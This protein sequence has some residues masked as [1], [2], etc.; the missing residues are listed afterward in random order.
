MDLMEFGYKNAKGIKKNPPRIQSCEYYRIPWV[1]VSIC[2]WQS[3]FWV[4]CFFLQANNLPLSSKDL[5][6]I[7]IE[8][9]VLNWKAF[10]RFAGRSVFNIPPKYHGVLLI[11]CWSF[12]SYQAKNLTA[13]FDSQFGKYSTNNTPP[14]SLLISFWEAFESFFPEMTHITKF[15]ICY[16]LTLVLVWSLQ[17]GVQIVCLLLLIPAPLFYFPEL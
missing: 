5:Q 10:L 7:P 16:F 12:L 3:S 1:C 14:Q 6:N 13:P 17:P 2:F 15:I 8:E 11:L 4:S 9:R